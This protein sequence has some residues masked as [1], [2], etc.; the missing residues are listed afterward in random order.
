MPISGP[1][2]RL[3]P[4]W[5]MAAIVLISGSTVQAAPIR[6]TYSGVITTADPLTGVTPGTP[7]TGSFF[8]DPAE[9]PAFAQTI[10]GSSNVVYGHSTLGLGTPSANDGINLTVGGQQVYSV[11]SGVDV[12]VTQ[13]QY[14]GQY[15]LTDASGN[16]KTPSTGVTVS[17]NYVDRDPTG[18]SVNLTNPSAA[19]LGSLN[20]PS[21]LNLYQFPSAMLT[22][23]G[24]VTGNSKTHTLYAGTINSLTAVSAIPAAEEIVPEPAVTSFLCLAAT[25]WLIRSRYRR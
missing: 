10:D 25:G 23:S 11:K 14:T 1:R 2:R 12:A 20:T 15:G 24:I 16:L 3:S 21:V 8:Y 22:V 7:F 4:E 17:N 9:R 19:V 6:Y 13:Q 18:V 5:L